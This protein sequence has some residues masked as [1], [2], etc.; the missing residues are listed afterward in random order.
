[1]D[2][3]KV[4]E[5]IKKLLHLADTAKNSNVEEAA[6]AA[7]KAQALIEKYRIEQAMLESHTQDGITWQL[8]A[9]KGRPEDWKLFL[10]GTLARHN[11]SYIVRS[12]TYTVDGQVWLV[13]EL[14]D[15]QTSQELYTYIVNELNRFCIAELIKYKVA[16]NI[17]PQ[18]SFTQSYYVGAISVVEERLQEATK[19][20]REEIVS[21]STKDEVTLAKVHHAIQR[22]DSK[23]E[24]AKDWIKTKF[25]VNFKNVSLTTTN[26]DGYTAG[27]EAGKKLNLDP[28]RA[29]LKTDKK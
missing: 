27:Q 23:S 24:A 17:Y 10:S 20:A 15:I 13:G 25:N 21:K 22:I 1:M 9:D 26:V 2:K 16:H 14:F 11:G 6:S 19:A 4:I 8:L 7:A 3:L 12:P 28:G 18:S 29:Q 5:K